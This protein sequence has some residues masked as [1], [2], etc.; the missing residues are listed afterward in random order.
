MINKGQLRS[1]LAAVV[2]HKAPITVDFSRV[3]PAAREFG[4]RRGTPIDRYYI[5]RYLRAQEERIF[6]DV[7]EVGDAQYTTCFS[8]RVASSRVLVP[9]EA[10]SGRPL[11]QSYLVADLTR[12]EQ[13]PEAQFDTFICTQTFNFIYDFKA[14]IAGAYRLLRRQGCLVGTVAGLSQV[15]VYDQSRWGDYWRFM[16]AGIKRALEEAFGSRVEVAA[17]GNA[18]AAHC[19]LEGVAVEDLPDPRILD[20]VD[21]EYP[22]VVG[23]IARKEPVA[24]EGLRV[25]AHDQAEPRSCAS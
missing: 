25:A 6:G 8:K 20:A 2:R 18:G 11:D 12:G 7:L 5:E 10:A 14:A 21:C 23:F 24:G 17:Y 19:Y 22:I 13:I 1:A 9:P 15:S 3:E 16:P 4:Y